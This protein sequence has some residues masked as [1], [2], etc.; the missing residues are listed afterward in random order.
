MGLLEASPR[1]VA[2][3]GELVGRASCED[4]AVALDLLRTS[5]VGAPIVDLTGVRYISRRAIG[6]L[7]ALW[8]DMKSKGR[9]LELQASDRVWEV[10]GRVGVAYV[11]PGKPT[12]ASPAEPDGAPQA[13]EVR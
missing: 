6:L 12:S 8:F 1:V 3:E 10:L 9:R 13:W 2:Y 11:F 5:G 7:V 4:F